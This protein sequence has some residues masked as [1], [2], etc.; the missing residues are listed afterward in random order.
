MTHH[1]GRTPAAVKSVGA[2][3]DHDADFAQAS[4]KLRELHAHATSLGLFTCDR[5]L[6]ACPSCG[7]QED[8]TIEGMLITHDFKSLDVSDSGLRF[9]ERQN[10]HFS[11]PRCCADIVA[12]DNQTMDELLLHGEE[13]VAK[14]KVTP[15]GEVVERLRQSLGCYRTGQ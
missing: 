15:V 8:V 11:C 7:M 10:G 12:G 9:T 3:G 14:G 6:L 13:Q 4:E 5:E 1:S 2:D